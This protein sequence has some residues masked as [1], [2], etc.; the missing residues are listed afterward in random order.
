MRVL[1][2]CHK[3]PYPPYDGG[4]IAMHQLTDGML[5]RGLEVKVIAIHPSGFANQ[6]MDTPEAYRSETGFEAIPVHTKINMWD[7]LINLFSK[8]S[9]NVE[10]FR[11]ECVSRRLKE[12]LQKESFDIILLEGLYLTPYIEVI[13]EHS[14]ASVI[15]RAHNIEHFIWRRLA[16]SS[17]HLL[18]RPYLHLLA[19]RLEQYEKQIIYSCD[20]LAAITEHD[21]AYFRDIGYSGPAE[22]IPVGIEKRKSGMPDIKEEACSVFHLGSM[23]WR[24]NR[25][26]LVWFL[27]KVWPGVVAKNP[28]L[29]FYLAGR[30][31]PKNFLRY[32]NESIS[33]LENVPDAL[34]FMMS[35]RLMVVPLLSGGGLRV[36]IIEGMA[37]GKAIVTTEVGAEG[38]GCIH[39]QHLL[40]ARSPEQM[41]YWI[42]QCFDKPEL[43]DS[44]G[45]R[46]RQ[47]A[48]RTFDPDIIIDRLIAFYRTF[49]DQ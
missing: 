20:G 43:A 13:R 6:L 19:R 33:L 46:A 26:G 31:I 21:L 17:R 37:A 44:M 41:V 28:D 38:T 39:Q 23:D 32:G 4:S 12:L 34:A 2:L 25:E 5:A 48:A 47:Y 24:P 42:L 35:K 45:K 27:E 36:K 1:Q 49:C 40:I 11:S 10:R 7:A 22:V 16:A 15:Y 30:N 14:R 18:K 8:R 3:I 9:Y 29:H